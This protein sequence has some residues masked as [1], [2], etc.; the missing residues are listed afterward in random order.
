MA[1]IR[2]VCG[3]Q[4]RSTWWCSSTRWSNPSSA[5]SQPIGRSCASSTKSGST[6]NVNVVS[7][8]S[9]PRP[10][11]ATWRTSGS[12]VSVAV[13]ISPVPVTSVRPQTCADK[14]AATPPVP[15]VPV[16]M[17]PAS[18][19]SAMSP[20]LCRLSP[21]AS[22]WRL[23]SLSWVPASAVTVIA[24]RSTARIPPRRVGRSMVCSGAEIAVKLWPVPTILSVVPSDRARSTAATIAAVPTGSSTRVG[25]ADSIPAQFLHSLT[26][27]W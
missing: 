19:C 13:T 23:S 1:S 18:V 20:M 21:S 8:P 16:E 15:W 6:R 2:S 4:Y 9:A 11:R 24:S 7:T 27:R 26:A 22:S 17:A 5:S 25:C 10:T 12:R 3:N 14:D